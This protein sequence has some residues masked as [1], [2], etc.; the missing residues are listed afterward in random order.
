[1][2][3]I[4]PNKL[5]DSGTVA[6]VTSKIKDI[7]EIFFD[8]TFHCSLT[9]DFIIKFAYEQSQDVAVCYES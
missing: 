1:M 8:V 9:K 6:M 3:F 7:S 2:A 5:A 4:L